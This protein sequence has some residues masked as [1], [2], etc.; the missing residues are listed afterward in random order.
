MRRGLLLAVLALLAACQRGPDPT[1][2][3]NA[4][5]F[6]RAGRTVERVSTSDDDPSE[7][8][9]DA[10]REA[11]GVMDLAKV[12]PGM[13][14]ADIGAGEGYYTVRLAQ[15][16]GRKGR[17]LGEDIDR[18]V[19]TRLGDRV[20][21]ERLDNVSIKL[22]DAVDPR[23]PP[24][25]FDRVFLVHMYHEV[26]EPYA[27]LWYLWPALR[28]GGRV[29]VVERDERG[30]GLSP[31]RLFCEFSA[32]GYRLVEFVRKPEIKGYYASFE[33]VWARPEPGAIQPCK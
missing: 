24:G 10:A 13:T 4:E 19:L 2:P 17:V 32:T 28:K 11:A 15:R 9:R 1:R 20:G 7:V 12:A 16:V 29:V 26:G 3:D 33:P 18:T 22:G 21:R 31:A 25:S 27:F 30:Y 14:V 5:A 23:L 8:D 6:P